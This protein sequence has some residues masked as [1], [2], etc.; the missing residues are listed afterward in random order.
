MLSY[1]IGA[2]MIILNAEGI[3]KKSQTWATQQTQSQVFCLCGYTLLPLQ[4]VW[5]HLKH[6]LSTGDA[7]MANKAG[8]TSLPNVSDEG[9]DGGQRPD[10][11]NDNACLVRSTQQIPTTAAIEASTS[12]HVLAGCWLMR[13]ID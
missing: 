8:R 10:Q 4:Y 6:S 3:A 13:L 2:K 9:C 11:C 5:S 1:H 12:R 7:P